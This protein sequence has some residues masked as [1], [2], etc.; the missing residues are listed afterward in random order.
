MRMRPTRRIREPRHLAQ[1][2]D[3]ALPLAAVEGEASHQG[4]GDAF[5]LGGCDVALVRVEDGGLRGLEPLGGAHQPRVLR[6]GAEGSRDP[7]RVAG[8]SGEDLDLLLQAHGRLVGRAGR[9]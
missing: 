4:R 8:V 3:H 6:V 1:P 9:G 2:V 7:R 5:L